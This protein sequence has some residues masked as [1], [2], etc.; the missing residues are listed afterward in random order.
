MSE[1]YPLS[2]AQKSADLAA[3]DKCLSEACPECKQPAGARCIS[4]DT[5]R[6]SNLVHAMRVTAWRSKHLA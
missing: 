5:Q 4:L 6:P 3:R 1:L 2:E